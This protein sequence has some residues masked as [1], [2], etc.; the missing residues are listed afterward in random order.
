[1]ECGYLT[2]ETPAGPVLQLTTFGS[3][4]RAIPGKASQTMQFD[5]KAA[6]ELREIIDRSF[7]RG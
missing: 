5:R 7:P 1:V 6:L 3:S 4:S 2:I